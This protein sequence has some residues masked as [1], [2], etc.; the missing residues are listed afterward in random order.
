[1]GNKFSRLIATAGGIGYLPVA[2]GTWAAGALAILWFII[3]QSFP[4]TYTWQLILIPII[5]GA[6]VYC[7]EKIITEKEKD[8]SHI[9][10]DE[11]AG[12][13]LTLLLIPPS[14]QN[15]IAGFIFFRFFDILKPFGIK[16]LENM[17]RGWGIMFDDV[18]AGI[19]S[20]IA[21]HLLI[22]LKIW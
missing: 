9:V 16:K 4:G 8:P 21:L 20:N 18:L 17:R 1:M 6:G 11:V 15:I 14:F 2:P 3:C 5:I 19:Y 22:L 13:S 10:I 12:M 7:S